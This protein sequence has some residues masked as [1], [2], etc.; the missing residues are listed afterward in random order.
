MLGAWHLRVVQRGPHRGVG[1]TLP[2]PERGGA[3]QWPHSAAQSLDLDSHRDQ[4]R[5]RRRYATEPVLMV[6][7]GSG[8]RFPLN[9]E[10]CEAESGDVLSA[11]PLGPRFPTPLVDRMSILWAA[12]CHVPSGGIA[13][14]GLPYAAPPVGADR[15]APP[16]EPEPWSGVLECTRFGPVCPQGKVPGQRPEAPGGWLRDLPSEFDLRWGR[17]TRPQVKSERRAP[18]S[19]RNL[20]FRTAAGSKTPS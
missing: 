7:G 11:P 20:K 3:T 19:Q 12:A 14:L 15:W 17:R 5:C 6:P 8:S 2:K 16:R 10:L 18:A 1:K 9:S 13:F 4:N